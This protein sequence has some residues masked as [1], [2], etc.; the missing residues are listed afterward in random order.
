M[1]TTLEH[2]QSD[3]VD[4][5]RPPSDHD[6]FDLFRVDPTAFRLVPLIYSPGRDEDSGIYVATDYVTWTKAAQ[7]TVNNKPNP[8]YLQPRL[9]PYELDPAG[10]LT[11]YLGTS[12]HRID[13][14]VDE[15]ATDNIHNHLLGLR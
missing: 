15:T 2:R 10:R 4:A 8:A 1:P 7:P 11:S 5:R 3:D 9:T 12:V 13:P 14:S 6:P